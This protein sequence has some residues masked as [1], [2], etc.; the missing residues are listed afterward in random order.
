MSMAVTGFCCAVAD[1]T[2]IIV[3]AHRANTTATYD[4]VHIH[5]FLLASDSA[6]AVH[7][8]QYNLVPD[9]IA[10]KATASSSARRMRSN[11]IHIKQSSPATRL[12]QKRTRRSPIAMSAFGTKRTCRV[13]LQCPLLGVKRHDLL[14]R[15]NVL[16]LT[17]SFAITHFNETSALDT[18]LPRCT[19]K[20]RSR[21]SNRGNIRLG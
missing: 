19:L 5:G 3:A 10:L 11:K 21:D 18:I 13:A 20:P 6:E 4:S 2:P 16:F 8:F 7:E 17:R 9:D 1:V 15:R 12:G 14:R